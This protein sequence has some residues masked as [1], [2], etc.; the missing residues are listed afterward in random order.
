MY[1][2]IIFPVQ[3]YCNGERCIKIFDYS[4]KRSRYTFHLTPSIIRISI[5]SL[6]SFCYYPMD[7]SSLRRIPRQLSSKLFIVNS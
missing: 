5:Y 7:C 4:D 3:F 6:F 1:V 2:A